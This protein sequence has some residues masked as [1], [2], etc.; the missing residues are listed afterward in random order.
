MNQNVSEITPAPML[1]HALTILSNEKNQLYFAISFEFAFTTSQFHSSKQSSPSCFLNALNLENTC[2]KNQN[3]IPFSMD[4]CSPASLKLFLNLQ[5]SKYIMQ[6]LVC[7]VKI[8]QNRYLRQMMTI[9]S[10]MDVW[11]L[12]FQL[13]I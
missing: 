4:A 2:K 8:L 10:V 7:L 1:S 13:K 5:F 3:K 12:R 6:I 11:P 9:L